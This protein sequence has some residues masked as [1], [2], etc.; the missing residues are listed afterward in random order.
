[1]TII[2]WYEIWSF[3]VMIV[4]LVVWQWTPSSVMGQ[5]EAAQGGPFNSFL[6]VRIF[7][8]SHSQ[9]RMGGGPGGMGEWEGRRREDVCIVATYIPVIFTSSSAHCWFIHVMSYDAVVVSYDAV[10]VSYDAVMVSYEAVIMISFWWCSNLLQSF[11]CINSANS[12]NSW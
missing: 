7:Q 1:M 8:P 10:M 11:I 9:D 2:V 5:S 4:W 3:H 12:A 6:V